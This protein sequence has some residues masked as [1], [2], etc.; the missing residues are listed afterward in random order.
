[1]VLVPQA[2]VDPPGVVLLNGE[3]H[4]VEPGNAYRAELDDV[5]AAIRGEWQ[6]VN[7]RAEMMGQARVL[8]ALLRSADA[9]TPLTP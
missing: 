7:D 4:R 8:D 9:G 3:A 2:F 6:V 5:C 1:V